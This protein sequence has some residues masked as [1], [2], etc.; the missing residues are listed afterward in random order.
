MSETV[1]E[2][3]T[4]TDGAAA[5]DPLFGHWRMHNR[6]LRDVLDPDCSE[7]VEF[8]A[9]VDMWP[10]LGGLGNIDVGKFELDV[11]FE[12]LTLRLYDPERQLW[13]IW[14]TSTRQ[15]G[16]MDAPVE[17]RFTKG[18]G[19][20]TADEVLAGRMTKVR[21][22][23]TGFAAGAPRWEQSFSYDDGQ[24]WRTNWIN[25]WVRAD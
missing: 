23:W 3:A 14:W 4:T 1:T 6:K 12:G 21:F 10:V 22:E 7:W 15:P 19:V 2:Q 25:T 9:T 18:R 13:R 24:T 11:P 17:G 16:Q 8:D 5:F 20:F